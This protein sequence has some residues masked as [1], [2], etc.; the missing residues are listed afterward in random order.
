MNLTNR[1]ILGDCIELL[2]ELPDNSVHAIISDI[3]YGI[4]AEDWDVLH[5]NSNS[6]YLGTSPAQRKAQATFGKRGKP[7]NGWSEADKRIP[8][9]YEEWCSTWAKE[10][11]RILVPGGS[12]LVFAGRRF[13]H[14]CIN[15]L[16][17]NGLSLKDQIAW[18]KPQAPHRAQRLSVV[19]ERRGDEAA[20]REWEGW[21]LG[22]LRPRF[23]P[24]IWA[25]K[26]YKVGTTLADNALTYGVGGYNPEAVISGG[27]TDSAN[28]LEAGTDR[29]EPKI[30][31]TQKPL[32][33][34][35][36]LVE[37]VTKPGQTVMDPFAG[38]GT[39]L[40]AAQSLGRNY[41]GFELNPEYHRLAQN[42]LESIQNTLL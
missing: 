20:A 8:L 3:P 30:H 7:I 15:A 6:A 39:T 12:A 4:G 31:P 17:S 29:S 28:I 19:Y 40:V 33:L 23:E 18:I 37:M 36:T 2:K 22:N 35:K 27:A 38:S 14:R 26:P 41:V 16:E 42:R 9:E 5:Q 34:M 21:R 32:R 25:V 13:E 10:W 11:S 1:L 24:I